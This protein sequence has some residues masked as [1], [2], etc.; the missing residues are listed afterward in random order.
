MASSSSN[1]VNELA[2]GIN[3]MLYKNRYNNKNC[4]TCRIKYKDC[5]CWLE[6]SNITDILIEYRCLCY[7]KN[8]QNI[9]D[10]NLENHVLTMTTKFILLLQNH[11]Y[12][13]E[14]MNR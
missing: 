11:I 3:K 9:F 14:Y 4:K 1:F 7:N 12:P 8:C 13:C 6:Y 2:K 10:G 5:G